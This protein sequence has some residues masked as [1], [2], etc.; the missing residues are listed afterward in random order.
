MFSKIS[1]WIVGVA[2]KNLFNKILDY[3]FSVIIATI[4]GVGYYMLDILIDTYNRYNRELYSL[5]IFLITMGFIFLVRI[6]L[7]KYN[8]IKNRL[9]A[10]DTR[11]SIENG[12]LHFKL[13]LN[14]L[15]NQVIE[16]YVDKKLS[17]FRV[18]DVSNNYKLES[19]K[20]VKIQLY[21]FATHA[22]WLDGIAFDTTN[23]KPNTPYK[24]EIYC[25][26]YLKYGKL[27]ENLDLFLTSKYE[28]IIA[29]EIDENIEYSLKAITKQPASP[30][31]QT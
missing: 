28:G 2:S 18:N 26:I 14:N 1:K 27:F 24:L 13:C 19:L 22:V 16:C 30:I 21:P 25:E 8:S 12:F 4:L 23:I 11:I 10:F 29:V 17:T 9:Q 7:K 5:Y 20:F 15:S 6:E 31:N 3:I